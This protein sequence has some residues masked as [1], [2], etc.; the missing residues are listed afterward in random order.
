MAD[1]KVIFEVVATAKGFNIVNKQ[2]KNLR[3]EIDKTTKSEKNLE[4]QRDKGYGRQQQ[5]IIQTANSTKNFSKLN[6]TIGGSSGSGALVSTYAL[7]AANVFAATAAFSALRNAAAVEKLGEG[8]TAFGN[9]SGQSLD[10]VSAKL[11][12]VT[13]NAVSLEQAMRTAALSTSAGFGV[14][15]MEGLTRVAKGASLALGRDM[16]DALDRLTRGAIKLEPEILDELGIMV[17]LDDAVETYAAQLGKAASGLTRFER[18]QAF[19]NAIITE[20]EAKFGGISD[21]IQ[22]NAY[23]NLSAA[24][25]DLSKN[26]LTLLNRALIP[27]INFFMSSPALF[28]GGILAMSGGITSRLIPAIGDL[29]EKSRLGAEQAKLT[30]QSFAEGADEQVKSAREVMTPT[31]ESA[32]AYNELTDKLSKGTQ[33][34]R[35]LG[36]AKSSLT[37]AINAETTAQEAQVASGLKVSKQAKRELADMV[38]KREALNDL[39]GAEIS[40]SAARKVNLALADENFYD[41]ESQVLAEASRAT[42]GYKDSLT[43]LKT[44]FTL[45]RLAVADYWREVVVAEGYTKSASITTKIL[46]VSMA[47]LRASVKAAT[48]SFKAF[49]T[50]ILGALPFLGLILIAFDILKGALKGIAKLFGFFAEETEIANKAQKDLATVLNGIADKMDAYDKIVERSTSSTKLLTAEFKVLGGIAKSAFDE[51]L[52]TQ[53]ALDKEGA[54]NKGTDSFAARDAEFFATR[55]VAA[56]QPDEDFIQDRLK[57]VDAFALSIDT[58]SRESDKVAAIVQKKLGKSFN[59]FAQEFLAAGNSAEDLAKISRQTMVEVEKQVNGVSQAA[60]GLATALKEAEKEGGKFLRTFAVKS[61][62]DGLLSALSGVNTE[63]NGLIEQAKEGDV[64]AT[65]LL[66]E[67]LLSLGPQVSL[68]A[69]SNLGPELDQVKLKS[70]ELSKA[71]MD[72]LRAIGKAEKANT[73]R[74]VK[75]REEELK[76]VRLNAAETF[77]KELPTLVK[78]LVVLQEIE[79]NQ[80][81][82][83]GLLKQIQKGAIAASKDARVKLAASQLQIDILAVEEGAIRRQLDLNSETLRQAQLKIQAGAKEH[84]LEETLRD[85]LI[86]KRGADER[87]LQIKEEQ[88]RAATLS[89]E[90][91]LEEIKSTQQLFN[92]TKELTNLTLDGAEKRNKINKFRLGENLKTNAK[93][94]AQAFEIAQERIRM[95]KLE[96]EIKFAVIEA[97]YALL[98]ARVATEQDLIN[99]RLK[100]IKESNKLNSTL[101]QASVQG[102]LRG[103]QVSI[104]GPEA[105]GDVALEKKLRGMAEIPSLN[106]AVAAEYIA[107]ADQ[108]KARIEASIITPEVF[109]LETLS[110]ALGNS[111]DIGGQ[112]L[113][114]SKQILDKTIGNLDFDLTIAAQTFS[115]NLGDNLLSQAGGGSALATALSTTTTSLMEDSIAK[116]KLAAGEEGIS[117]EKKAEL[118]AK[119]AA[120]TA[121]LNEFKGGLGQVAETMQVLANIS[122]SIFGEDGILISGIAQFS[123][124]I[125]GS[126][127]TFFTTFENASTKTEK[128]AAKL[129]LAGNITAAFGALSQAAGQAKVAEVDQA[130]EAEKRR[131]GKSKESLAKIAALEKK[132]DSMA[133]KAFE[134]NK[135]I[136]MAQTIINTASAIVAVLDDVPAPYN[137][138]LAALVGAM[139]AAQLGMIAKTQYQSTSGGGD[140]ATPSTALNIGSRSNSIDVSQR[141]SG[142]EL[143]YL[144]GGQGVGT[145]ANNFTP[146][147]MGRKGYADGADGITVGERGPEVITAAAPIDIIPNYALGSGTTNVNFNISAVDGQSVQNMLNEQQGNIIAMIRQAANDNG[148][149]FLETVDPTVYGGTGG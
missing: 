129:E 67:S 7:L 23:D 116:L 60:E 27:I 11:K 58:L 84:E 50:A 56:G 52:K 46:A 124:N 109:R 118:D 121:R 25:A 92:L 100:S 19:M 66:S 13:G 108:V 10:L 104:E 1:N 74:I 98:K 123:A 33:T 102:T 110:K 113:E 80:K 141:A 136:Q 86:Q 28:L 120:A 26:M 38:K 70:Q 138:A 107:L 99:A 96:A 106:P 42:L 119:I 37:K 4:K 79:L 149:G 90:I 97:E 83:V 49:G 40:Q 135:K 114:I 41:K 54:R 62:Y 73:Q 94:A 45:T 111:V 146:A 53:K 130:I 69:G 59:D 137:F 144:R 75:L 3:N 115:K 143:A 89:Q 145:N 125:V 51:A 5:A 8:L 122:R 88:I 105:G 64:D 117:E 29:T 65:K 87:I 31:K 57:N 68:L 71:R 91:T 2:Q 134:R 16:G 24:L 82:E 128:L 140:T 17:R 34:S 77:K 72:S 30:A 14:A 148:E 61:K 18:Q 15:E 85:A 127:D 47:T 103:R 22:P 39:T 132:K 32:K 55:N 126:F 21:S 147:A 43:K 63:L 95:S 76:V 112:S 131:D 20:G 12:E 6:Q 101:G 44:T 139:G 142:G 9:E 93:E 81:R 35:E 78:K 36:S 48:L 133:R